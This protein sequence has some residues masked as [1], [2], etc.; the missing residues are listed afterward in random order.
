MWAGSK[1]KNSRARES[2]PSKTAKPL[3]VNGE[4]GKLEGKPR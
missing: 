3:R 4:T 1:T 2:S